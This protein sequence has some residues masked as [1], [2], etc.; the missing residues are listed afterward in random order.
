VIG[1]NGLVFGIDMLTNQQVTLYGALMPILVLQYKQWWRLLTSG[2]LHADIIHIAFNLY[3][4]Y[5]LGLLT[6]RFLG[7]R[8]FLATYGLSLVGCSVLVTLFSDL[9]TLTVGASGAIMGVLGAMVIFFWKYRDQLLGGRG[10]LNQLIRMA[11]I[12]I[13]IGLL[14]GIS[15]WGHLGGFLAGMASGLVLLPQYQIS[16][17]QVTQLELRPLSGRNWAGL[18]AVIG[19]ELA[20]LAIALLWRS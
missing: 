6:E 7:T 14:P 8:R 9:R 4:F 13:G 16:D 18:A 10:F 5:N 2:F 17:W 15:W 12:N 20:L 11:L 1:I 19:A 3:A